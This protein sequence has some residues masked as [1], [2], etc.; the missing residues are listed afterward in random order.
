[1]SLYHIE[2]VEGRTPNLDTYWIIEKST[3][4]RVLSVPHWFQD[5]KEIANG[6]VAALDKAKIKLITKI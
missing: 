6:V 5:S 4:H 1:M 2:K 3:G